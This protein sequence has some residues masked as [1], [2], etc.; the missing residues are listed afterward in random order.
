MWFATS[1]KRFCP[2][3][4]DFLTQAQ[5]DH[6]LKTMRPTSIQAF[7]MLAAGL[8]GVAVS[9]Q[10]ATKHVRRFDNK[11]AP[12]VWPEYCGE[13]GESKDVFRTLT[14]QQD[15]VTGEYKTVKI[16]NS[17]ECR[18]CGNNWI[19]TCESLPDPETTE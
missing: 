13:C 9:K 2:P 19:S 10:E 14:Q 12:G 16:S 11:P 8:Y 1:Q 6:V 4:P 5:A 18:L 3:V 15:P 7:Q 17:R